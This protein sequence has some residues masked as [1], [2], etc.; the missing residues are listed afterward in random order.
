MSSS[1]ECDHHEFRHSHIESI[2]VHSFHSLPKLIIKDNTNKSIHKHYNSA[3][4]CVDEDDCNAS[5]SCSSSQRFNVFSTFPYYYQYRRHRHDSRSGGDHV[6]LDKQLPNISNIHENFHTKNDLCATTFE[7]LALDFY[8]LPLLCPN[9]Q[10]HAPELQYATPVDPK[11]EITRRLERG[12]LPIGL[13]LDALACHGQDGCRVLQ[14]LGGGAVARDQFIVTNDYVTSL[15]GISMRYLDNLKAFKILHS[16]SQNSAII[17][18]TFFPASIIES[19][20]IKCL[21]KVMSQPSEDPFQKN[22]IPYLSIVQPLNWSPAIEIVL[23]RIDASQ[24]WGL[25]VSG[26]DICSI[27]NCLAPLNLENPSILSEILPNSVGSNCKLL[28]CGLLI[29]KIQGND[30]STKGANYVNAYLQHLSNQSDLCELHLVVCHFN[31]SNDDDFANNTTKCGIGQSVCPINQLPLD[32]QDINNNNNN[33]NNSWDNDFDLTGKIEL[34][35]DSNILPSINAQLEC[36]HFMPPR[37]SPSS[38]DME[39]PEP[40]TDM[41]SH[42]IVDILCRSDPSSD[43]NNFGSQPNPY[44]KNN[45]CLL[46]QL[47]SPVLKDEDNTT[48]DTEVTFPGVKSDTKM[49]LQ[50]GWFRGGDDCSF[51]SPPPPRSLPRRLSVS[52]K[53]QDTEKLQHMLVVDSNANQLNSSDLVKFYTRYS[54]DEIHVIRLPLLHNSPSNYCPNVNEVMRNFDL[55]LVSCCNPEVLATFV[56]KCQNNF[57]SLDSDDYLQWGDEIVQVE[58]ISVCGLNHL[59]VQQIIH[60]KVVEILSNKVDN[61]SRTT[62]YHSIGSSDGGRI[63]GSSQSFVKPFI[64]LIIRRNPINRS[65]ISSSHFSGSS[66][67]V[68]SE[69]SEVYSLLNET[70]TNK[71]SSDAFSSPSPSFLPTGSKPIPHSFLKQIMVELNEDFRKFQL[72]D[73]VLERGSDGFGIFIVN[74]GRNNEPGVFVTEIR[75]N[76][77]ASLAVLRPHDRI[78]AIDGQLQCDYEST[79][80]LLQQSRKSVRLTIGRQISY[81]S[82]PLSSGRIITTGNNTDVDDKHHKLPI[83]P[84]IPSSV[85]LYKTDGGLGFSIVGGS[86]TILGNILIHEVHSGGAAARDGRL[87][88]GDRLLAVNGIDLRDA[89]QKGATKI[90]RTANDCIQLIVYRDPEPQYLNHDMFECHNVHLKRD[91]P[92]CSF[93]LSLI[94]RPHY[95]TGTAIGAI[96]ENSPAARSNLLEVGDVILEINGWDMRLAKSEEVITLLKNVHSDVKLLIGRYKTAPSS[97]AYP[98]NRLH[99]Y[100]VVLERRQLAFSNDL[101]H[102]KKCYST[103]LLPTSAHDDVNKHTQ[104]EQEQHNSNL[105]VDLVCQ[106]TD[107]S[108]V[109]DLY[110]LSNHSSTVNDDHKS[111]VGNDDEI[112]L[113][114]FGLRIRQANS[115]ELWDSHSRLIVDSVQHNSPADRSGMIMPGDRLLSVDR[116]PVDWLNPNEVVQLLANLPYCTIELGRLP[117]FNTSQSTDNNPISNKCIRHHSPSAVSLPTSHRVQ[118]DEHDIFPPYPPPSQELPA[119]FGG[120]MPNIEPPSFLRDMCTLPEQQDEYDESKTGFEHGENDDNDCYH[121]RLSERSYLTIYPNNQQ[122]QIDS[123]SNMTP[124]NK[125]EIEKALE[126]AGRSSGGFFVRQIY[127][128]I[129]PINNINNTVKSNHQLDIHLGLRLTNGPGISGPVVVRITPNSCASRTDIQIGDRI[130]G[131]DDKLLLSLSQD[132]NSADDI[133]CTIESVWIT[134]SMNSQPIYEQNPCCLTIVSNHSLPLFTSIGQ[135]KIDPMM[136]KGEN[137]IKCPENNTQLAVCLGDLHLTNDNYGSHNRIDSIEKENLENHLVPSTIITPSSFGSKPSETTGENDYIQ[138]NEPKMDH[139]YLD[140]GSYQDSISLY[141][142]HY[143]L[144]VHLYSDIL[145][146]SPN[147]SLFADS[148]L[149]HM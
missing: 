112:A 86:D 119:L 2:I 67:N 13:K 26:P 68:V 114:A 82:D 41:E 85:T 109:H 140:D 80:E 120:I 95:S 55:D 100:V 79:L 127:L 15:N 144:P 58:D 130:L 44:R 139:P 73:I 39:N 81:L 115:Q 40:L 24:Q 133:L 21:S 98:R 132:N 12:S 43:P 129:A 117:Y 5:H 69:T 37:T 145:R 71:N 19:H 103:H 93:G 76:S 53:Y 99:V 50:N 84:G 7:D 88:V 107:K 148:I 14:V 49:K 3:H 142:H 111:D 147:K 31:D 70:L 48:V 52:P 105:L 131:L 32:S 66:L 35:N 87:Q 62:Y 101:S 149:R 138:Y 75:E 60:S 10:L 36:D 65:L 108:E 1:I 22:S 136:E 94:D 25:V 16:L 90:I 116:E 134:R 135:R 42:D 110:S 6:F 17:D 91:M 143:E 23:Y 57:I 34:S 4:C 137:L 126:L 38:S 56:A 92:G 83:I 61:N 96:T 51:N 27:F 124:L 106:K 18:I 46:S 118:Q 30:V 47:S 146:H 28:S 20:R 89:T 59:S 104:S 113:A 123:I 102:V 54:Q 45:Q 74:M 9:P 97:H 72:F 78:L 122:D 8:A 125:E 64:S 141:N 121:Y 128:P 63:D 29:L 77:P 11:L 33:N